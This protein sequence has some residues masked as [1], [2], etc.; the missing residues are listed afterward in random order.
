MW[1]G[2]YEDEYDAENNT[3]GNIGHIAVFNDVIHKLLNWFSIRIKNV[4][5]FKDSDKYM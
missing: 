2:F 1:R 4:V 3:S 5:S